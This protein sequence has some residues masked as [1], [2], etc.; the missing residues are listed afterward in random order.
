MRYLTHYI[1]YVWHVVHYVYGERYPGPLFSSI[2]CLIKL[3][4]AVDDKDLEEA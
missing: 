3:C 4:H 1:L 2:S